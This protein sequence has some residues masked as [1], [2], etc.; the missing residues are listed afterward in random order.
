MVHRNRRGYE[1]MGMTFYG[2]RML[3]RHV[4]SYILLSA[5]G[6]ALLAPFW[7]CGTGL[8]LRSFGWVGWRL[9][10]CAG[11]AAFGNASSCCNAALHDISGFSYVF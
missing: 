5:L 7:S 1:H 4:T 3:T 2:L 9:R 6:I 8:A 11:R 10:S